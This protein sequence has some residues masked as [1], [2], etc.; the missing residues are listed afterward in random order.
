MFL[1]QT[2]TV[3]KN[4][5]VA[6]RLAH[7]TA[8]KLLVGFPMGTRDDLE[9]AERAAYAAVV[10]LRDAVEASVA[11]KPIVLSVRAPKTCCHAAVDVRGTHYMRETN[12]CLHG[13]RTVGTCD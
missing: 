9:L 4:K 6:A 13:N 5:L 11:A 3:L 7:S 10:A 8:K 12:C 1:M 2:Q